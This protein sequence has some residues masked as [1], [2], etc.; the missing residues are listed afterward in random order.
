[1]KKIYSFL[2]ILALIVVGGGCSDDPVRYDPSS[3]YSDNNI[4]NVR[5]E[6]YE[7]ALNI[8][9]LTD[10]LIDKE[11]ALSEAYYEIYN[12]YRMFDYFG[13]FI[14][15]DGFFIGNENISAEENQIVNDAYII[16]LSLSILYLSDGLLGQVTT[17][18]GAFTVHNHVS[19]FRNNLAVALDK[20]VRFG[21]PENVRLEIYEI[22][23]GI[24]EVMD[25][26]IDG[27]VTVGEAS[28][29]IT[30]LYEMFN[31]FG[32]FISEDGHFVRN[33]DLSTGENWII[34]FAHQNDIIWSSFYLQ[35]RNGFRLDDDTVLGFRNTFSV[36]L[37]KPE[38]R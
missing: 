5:L 12:L 37:N 17:N 31:Y 34:M 14:S 24:L 13:D 11:I 30:E 19:E 1:M 29:R 6:I 18:A 21:Q 10:Q 3:E 4:E 2:L 15:E 27:Q 36:P 25:S 32:D 26:F 7:S 35:Y 23:I 22:G 8:L 38:R 33:E 20:S 9:E 16:Y 28:S